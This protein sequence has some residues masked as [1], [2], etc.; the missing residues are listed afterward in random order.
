MGSYDKL[1]AATSQGN[2]RACLLKASALIYLGKLPEAGM[3][4]RAAAAMPG[5]VSMS[6]GQELMLRC[7]LERSTSYGHKDVCVCIFVCV[8]MCGCVCLCMSALCG[9]CAHV[10]HV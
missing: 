9:A 7:S 2:W 10:L 8:R 6:S 4:L 3:S 1:L 5:T